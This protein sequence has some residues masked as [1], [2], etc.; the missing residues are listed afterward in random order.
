MKLITKEIDKKLTEAGYYGQKAICKFFCP[1]GAATWI[2]FG[3]DEEDPNILYGVA[4]LG[5]GSVEAGGIY[6]PELEGACGPAG[7]TI[8]R[9]MYFEGGESISHYLEMD[10]LVGV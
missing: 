8:E 1:W 6:L 10:S 5:F 3:R 9:D 7:L 2:I 4:D